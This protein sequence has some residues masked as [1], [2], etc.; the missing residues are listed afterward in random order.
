LRVLQIISNLGAGGA[1]KLVEQFVPI[2]NEKENLHVDILLLT[3][4]GNVFEKSLKER[5]GRIFTVP[6]RKPRNPLNVFYIWDFVRKGR[7]D[8]VHVHLFPTLYWVSLAARLMWKSK[9]P[10]LV[11][12]EHSTH[13]RRR[14]IKAFRVVDRIMYSVYDK[15]I[16]V[17]N[18]TQENLVDWLGGQNHYKF[19]TIPNGVNVRRIKE[20]KPYAKRDLHS[21][22]SE[23]TVI[24]CMVGRF[25]AVKDQA[26]VIRSLVYLPETVHLLLVGDGPRRGE[27][28]SLVKDLGIGH[29]THFLGFR[30]DVDRIMNTVDV[31][32]LSSKWEGLPVTI[33]EAMAAGKPV[34]GTDVE[35]IS[36]VVRGYGLL[37]ERGDFR[38]LAEIVLD[39][40][41][42]E[43]KIHLIGQ[44]CFERAKF[45][46]IYKM[47]EDYVQVYRSLCDNL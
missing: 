41:V 46:D 47:V 35:G 17:S 40:V 7:Y 6:L 9:R 16:S 14:N 27:M 45:F 31:V 28:E 19:I 10:K 20:A 32:V 36:D 21:A 43:G 42:N 13:N 12:T 26:T 4:K 18:K 23:E 34:V 30:D 24:L 1:E 8:V 29:R 39:L 37:F 33:I 44:R 22:F 3:D 11:Y 5:G 25:S 15:I 2:M 38:Q